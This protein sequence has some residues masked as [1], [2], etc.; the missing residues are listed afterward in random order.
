MALGRE[1]IADARRSSVRRFLSLGFSKNDLIEMRILHSVRRTKRFSMIPKENWN[2]ERKLRF[3][4]S[5]NEAQLNLEAQSSR[6]NCTG[7]DWKAFHRPSSNGS[8][9]VLIA[10]DEPGNNW[11]CDDTIVVRYLKKKYN[12]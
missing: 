8:G 6:Y 4:K 9:W 12:Q 2:T 3:I 7:I 11:Y 1:L 10:P 5:C